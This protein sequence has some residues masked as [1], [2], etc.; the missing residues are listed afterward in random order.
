MKGASSM[1]HVS[2]EDSYDPLFLAW[3]PYV[4]KTKILACNIDFKHSDCI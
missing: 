4:I 3:K 1:T 2:H